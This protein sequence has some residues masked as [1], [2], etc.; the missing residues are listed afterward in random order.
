MTPVNEPSRSPRFATTRWSVVVAAGG[1][2]AE[3]AARA[4]LDDLCAAYWY[5]LYAFAR[6]RG[7]APADAEDLVQGFFAS[8]LERD[9]I[10]AADPSRGRFRAFLRTAFERHAASEHRKAA[11]LKRGGGV[12]H[13]A[14]E[15][16]TSADGERRYAS[17]PSHAD[18]PERVFERRW[19]LTVVSRALTRL[20][21]ADDDPA[22]TAALLPFV[23]GPG[24][25]KPYAEVAAS[26][27]MA[28]DAVKTAVHRLRK[29]YR[30]VLRDEVAHT[31][32]GPDEVDDELRRLFDALA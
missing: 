2:R 31:V 5:P 1:P 14:L 19:A 23:G 3:P 30:T 25:A 12:R 26:L 27:G 32:D 15:A 20:R 7:A 29:R 8:L 22:R 10:G 16:V 18:T 11:A 24:E 21:D 4:A 13:A 17:E 9:S 28:E 6:R